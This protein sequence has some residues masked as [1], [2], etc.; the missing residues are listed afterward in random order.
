MTESANTVL[1]DNFMQFLYENMQPKELKQSMDSYNLFREKVGITKNDKKMN[2]EKTLTEPNF[3]L[4]EE[5]MRF[6]SDT[7]APTDPF[8]SEIKE[9]YDMFKT[10]MLAQKKKPRKKKKKEEEKKEE[11]VL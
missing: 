10:M 3:V 6:V 7:S 11:E 4:L 8:L 9:L 5:F 1:I 2:W